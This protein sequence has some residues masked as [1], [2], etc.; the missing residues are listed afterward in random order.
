MGE[1]GKCLQVCPSVP[2]GGDETGTPEFLGWGRTVCCARPACP[3]LELVTRRDS[4]RRGRPL[5]GRR[6]Q[7]CGLPP[8]S[9]ETGLRR[10]V[11][12]PGHLLPLFLLSTASRS[13]CHAGFL[14]HPPKPSDKLGPLC[15]RSPPWNL[16][17]L[18]RVCCL[19]EVSAQRSFSQ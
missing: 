8:A 13:S 6:L 18:S 5:P 15:W 12:S 10:A 1:A 3:V 16:L 11:S 17:P 9:S 4:G 7:S 14:E 19:L 2:E